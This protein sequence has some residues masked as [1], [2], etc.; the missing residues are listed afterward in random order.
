MGYLTHARWPPTPCKHS[1]LP[2]CGAREH[3]LRKDNRMPSAAAQPPQAQ[4]GWQLVAPIW[5]A[6]LPGLQQYRLHGGGR[7]PDLLGPLVLHLN[8]NHLTMLTWATVQPPGAPTPASPGR[9]FSCCQ[10]GWRALRLSPMCL[11]GLCGRNL[12]GGLWA[13]T[14]PARP[15][16]RASGH[17]CERVQLPLLQAAGPRLP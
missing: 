7:L 4:P 17:H 5:F 13:L 16:L 10:T 9:S 3:L 1:P 12:P 15:V 2:N 11:P 8:G 14:H 6:A